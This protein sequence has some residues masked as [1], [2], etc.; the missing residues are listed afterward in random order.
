MVTTLTI[1][2][3]KRQLNI[4]PEFT[5]DDALLQRLLNTAV[6]AVSRYMPTGT[7]ATTGTTSGTTEITIMYDLE[8]VIILLAAHY[9]QNRNMVSFGSGQEIPYTFKFL[10]NHFID[11]PIA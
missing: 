1:Q 3:L 2:D 5:D 4:E 9:Y 7:T 6:Q 8:Q 11:Y 10:L